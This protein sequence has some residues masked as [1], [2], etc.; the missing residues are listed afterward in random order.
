MKKLNILVI[1]LKT[2]GQ[3]IVKQLYEYNCDVLAVDK[4][5]DRVEEVADY[6]TE[7]IQLDIKDTTELKK[8]PLDNF[9]VAV[10]T[11]K[12]LGANI[13]AAMLCEEAGIEK[14]IV[15]S[16]SNLHKKILEKIGIS[17]IISP[18]QE[19]GI[20]L[21]KGIMDINVMEAINISENYDIVEIKAQEKWIGKT[22]RDLKFR[23]NFGMNVLLVKK[24]NTKLEISPNGD[25]RIESG[26]RLVVIDDKNSGDV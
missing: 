20:R 6:A 15:R 24:E 4:D 14:I 22:L 21:A 19:M 3:S 25:Y 10:I 23:N 12:D 18:D 5:I 1:G 26:D 16:T 8:L 9:D 7:A 11:L 13:M 17:T 2:F